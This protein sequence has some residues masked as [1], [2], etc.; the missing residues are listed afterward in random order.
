MKKIVVVVYPE[1]SFISGGITSVAL[2]NAIEDWISEKTGA[3]V[4]FDA[5]ES[6]DTLEKVRYDL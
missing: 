3:T 4:E 5:A 2:E 1:R 6:V